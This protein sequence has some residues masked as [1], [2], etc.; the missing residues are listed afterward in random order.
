MRSYNVVLD[1]ERRKIWKLVHLFTCR[2]IFDFFVAVWRE[3]VR[4][5]QLRINHHVE[6]D[7]QVQ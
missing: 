5:G 6:V 3:T 1:L 4:I 7:D 2:P